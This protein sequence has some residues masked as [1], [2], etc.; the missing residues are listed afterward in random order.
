MKQTW[1]RKAGHAATTRIV[2]RQS[3]PTPLATAVELRAPPPVGQRSSLVVLRLVKQQYRFRSA[4][5]P[6]R[7]S[8]VRVF[9]HQ[10]VATLQYQI[11]STVCSGLEVCV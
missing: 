2:V 11:E 1:R 4:T 10:A 6:A 7:S 3:H 9:V 8:A 5:P